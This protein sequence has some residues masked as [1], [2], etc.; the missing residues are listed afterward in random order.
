MER[1]DKQIGPLLTYDGMRSANILVDTDEECQTHLTKKVRRLMGGSGLYTKPFCLECQKD[2]LAQKARSS[3]INEYANSMFTKSY[4]VFERASIISDNLTDK[5]LGNFQKLG[6]EDEQAYNFASRLIREYVKGTYEGNAFIQGN[7]GIGKSHLALGIAK[8][9]ND[10]FKAYNEPK[11]VI[12][13][14]V[15]SLMKKIKASFN[16]ESNFTEEY[17]T[18]LLTGC[19]YLVLDDLGKESTSAGEIKK[20]SS[21]VYTF[22]FDILDKRKRTIVTTNFSIAELTRI[23]DDAFVDRL[24]KGNGNYI[25]SYPPSAQSKRRKGYE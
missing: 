9:I 7:P 21:W 5:S 18:K 10:G 25:F 23:Y 20:A 16:G 3:A 13:M 15:A 14:P 2:S 24:L 19:D 12:F 6:A 17:A 8:K 22:L 4:Y 11:S 1:F